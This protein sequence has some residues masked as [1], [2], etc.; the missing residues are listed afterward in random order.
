MPNQKNEGEGN[1]TAAKQY[2]KETQDFVKSDRVG[3]AAAEAKRAM[4][5]KEGAELDAAHA[6]AAKHAHG[7]D[8]EE[9]RDYRKGQ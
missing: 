6:K 3:K 5:G 4:S 8:P 7:H 2:N 9:V 1:R